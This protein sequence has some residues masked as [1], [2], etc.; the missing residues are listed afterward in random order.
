MKLDDCGE[1]A[2]LATVEALDR[3]LRKVGPCD[4]F[5]KGFVKWSVYIATCR[6]NSHALKFCHS[7]QK[8]EDCAIVHCFMNCIKIGRS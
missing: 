8:F 1:V 2:E 6:S 5:A 4:D 7:L 3:Q